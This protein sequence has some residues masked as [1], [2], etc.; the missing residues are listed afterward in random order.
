MPTSH[1]GE[2]TG[3]ARNASRGSSLNQI[4]ATS[5]RRVYQSVTISGLISYE[6]IGVAWMIATD[7]VPVVWCVY[8]Q[9]LQPTCLIKNE[10]L[11]VAYSVVCEYSSMLL[12]DTKAVHR[13][14][15]TPRASPQ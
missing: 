7:V 3:V 10:C 8:R 6:S 15:V 2:P 9:R 11:P 13:S 12:P 5:I 1:I 14:W 4:L